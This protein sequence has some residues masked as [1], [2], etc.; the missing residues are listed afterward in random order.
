MKTFD[1]AELNRRAAGEYLLP[2]RPGVP[3]TSPFWNVASRQFTYVP[4]FDVPEEAGAVR[5]RVQAT[6]LATGKVYTALQEKPWSPIE[7]LWRALPRAAVRLEV[8]ALDHRGNVLRQLDIGDA[9][10]REFCRRPGFHGPYPQAVRAYRDCALR[11]LKRV[12]D[13]ARTCRLVET[14]KADPAVY[15]YFCYPTLILSALMYGLVRYGAIAPADHDEAMR[16]ARAAADILIRMSAPEGGPLAFLPP[17]YQGDLLV[18]KGQNHVIQMSG[19]FGSMG[20]YLGIYAVTQRGEVPRC[21]A[22]SRE[23]LRKA[24]TSGRFLVPQVRRRDWSHLSPRTG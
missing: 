4:A 3:G 6:D 20:A 2:V 16:I 12:F 24:A 22:P 15:G 10:S 7:E 11:S 23:H 21:S 13:F 1:W 18:A 8:F 9:P 19:A 17:T 5:Y 14:G